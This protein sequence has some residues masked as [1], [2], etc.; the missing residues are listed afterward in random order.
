[1]RLPWPRR[2]KSAQPDAETDERLYNAAAEASLIN[3]IADLGQLPTGWC[4]D[5]P[6]AGYERPCAG[7]G[8]PEAPL[9]LIA[10]VDKG[11]CGGSIPIPVCSTHAALLAKTCELVPLRKVID[12]VMATDPIAAGSGR[13]PDEIARIRCEGLVQAVDALARL[14][15]GDPAAGFEACFNLPRRPCDE[16]TGV[17]WQVYVRA[18]KEVPLN[19]PSVA[20]PAAARRAEP[21][22]ARRAEAPVP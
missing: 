6:V 1:M 19:A 20:E 22:A 12:K 4:I 8:S 7:C 17:R 14:Q 16:D 2:K 15:N 18:H 10:T 5:T 11:T 13:R 21:A 3:A 9:I